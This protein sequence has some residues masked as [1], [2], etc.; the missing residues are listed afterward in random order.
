MPVVTGYRIQSSWDCSDSV[1]DSPRDWL[2]GVCG[3]RHSQNRKPK[4]GQGTMIK[5][6]GLG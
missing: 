4:A 3:H 1:T 6:E 2:K 5:H